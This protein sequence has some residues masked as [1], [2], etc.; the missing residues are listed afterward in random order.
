[1]VEVIDQLETGELLT[2]SPRCYETLEAA[3]QSVGAALPEGL[4]ARGSGVSADALVAA[5]S[6]SIAT[7]FDGADRSGPSITISGTN[8][9]GG[10]LNLSSSWVNRIS[11]TL[12]GCNAVTF[13]DGANR[14]GASEPTNGSTVNLKG[15]DD[16]ANSVQYSS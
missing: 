6:G 15:L 8:C 13:F 16:A 11:S 7:H 4:D 12:N 3:L 14:S 2:S 9:N 5:A 10:W 1:V